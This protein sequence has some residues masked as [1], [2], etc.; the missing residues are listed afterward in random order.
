MSTLNACKLSSSGSQV[1]AGPW[2]NQAIKDG[3]RKFIIQEPD[4]GNCF[5]GIWDNDKYA[6]KFIAT[7]NI[8]GAGDR[9]SGNLS[10]MSCT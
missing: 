5:Y 2:I 9:D 6:S 8:N 3:Y 10:S 7:N 4:I 1:D